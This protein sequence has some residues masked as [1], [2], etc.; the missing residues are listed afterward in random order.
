MDKKTCA[1]QSNKALVDLVPLLRSISI[2]LKLAQIR[3]YSDIGKITKEIYHQFRDLYG[4]AQAIDLDRIIDAQDEVL[5][6][7]MQSSQMGYE[8][9]YNAF[10]EFCN[11]IRNT[12]TEIMNS[13]VLPADKPEEPFVFDPM[14]R[15]RTVRPV[16]RRGARRP[17][18]KSVAKPEV[19]PEVKPEPKPVVQPEATHDEDLNELLSTTVNQKPVSPSNDSGKGLGDTFD[20]D[21]FK[22]LLSTTVNK[23]PVAYSNDNVKGLENSFSDDD[24][25]SGNSSDDDDF[26]ELLST[27]VNKKPVAHSNDSSKGLGYSSSDDDSDSGNSSDDDDFNELL[28]TTVNQKTVVPSNAYVKGLADTFDEDDF[29]QLLA[30]TRS[31]KS[32]D[33][34]KKEAPVDISAKPFD[35]E[36]PDI[37]E[38][39]KEQAQLYLGRLEYG[40]PRTY[41]EAGKMMKDMYERIVRTV[42][43]KKNEAV[44]KTLSDRLDAYYYKGTCSFEELRDAFYMVEDALNKALDSNGS[45]DEE[46]LSEDDISAKPFSKEIS[47]IM[48]DIKKYAEFWLGGIEYDEPETYEKAAR[49]VKAIYE[50]TMHTIA[51][52]IDEA[53]LKNLLDRAKAYDAGN[54]SDKELR[55]AFFSL[56]EAIYKAIDSVPKPEPAKEET[57]AEKEK[58]LRACLDKVLSMYNKL[59]KRAHTIIGD[60]KTESPASMDDVKKATRN[61]CKKIEDNAVEMNEKNILNMESS[62]DTY[63]KDPNEKNGRRVIISYK[64]LYNEIYADLDYMFDDSLIRENGTALRFLLGTIPEIIEEMKSHIAIYFARLDYGRP[65]TYRE[66]EDTVKDIYEKGVRIFGIKKNEAVLK[67]LS[68]RVEAYYNGECSSQELLDAFYLAKE[69]FDKACNSTDEVPEAKKKKPKN[70]SLLQRNLETIF[71]NILKNHFSAAGQEDDEAKNFNMVHAKVDSS[72]AATCPKWYNFMESVFTKLGANK[73]YTT[74]KILIAILLASCCAA[75][76]MKVADAV[77]RAVRKITKDAKFKDEEYMKKAEEKIRKDI[78]SKIGSFKDPK[79]LDTVVQGDLKKWLGLDNAL[80]TLIFGHVDQ[81]RSKK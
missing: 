56:K 50:R 46:E 2:Q 74:N 75:D 14:A 77:C 52:E 78:K 40:K 22:A 15:R 64:E 7:N 37:L 53:A 12:A 31:N 41:G 70:V 42:G 47:Q 55:D 60:L 71:G 45:S 5:Y 30:T 73:K 16:V 28:S 81:A 62:I 67:T 54:C 26:N 66:A 63:N 48:Q 24:S 79:G 68:D 36:I 58:R 51:A 43:A 8:P 6:R 76:D 39:V 35:E 32:K 19:K 72:T 9:V 59:A 49:I 44:L 23:K 38:R 27:T 13:G 61:M 33:L 69:A 10:V 65:K 20:E 4:R 1:A 3:E 29:K 34:E 17:V 25:D 18:V 80:V 57:P 21:D 11:V